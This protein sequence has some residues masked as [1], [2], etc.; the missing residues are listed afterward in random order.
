MNE[1]VIAMKGFGA[2]FNVISNPGN[3]VIYLL[4]NLG[5]YC[6]LFEFLFIY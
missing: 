4:T 6:L 1:L 2:I 3:M 5:R